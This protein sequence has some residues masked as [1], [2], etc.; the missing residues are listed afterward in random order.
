MFLLCMSAEAFI[1]GKRNKKAG[2]NYKNWF[3]EQRE[4]NWSIVDNEYQMFFMML[5]NVIPVFR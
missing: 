1:T 3:A 2:N 5:F 4:M